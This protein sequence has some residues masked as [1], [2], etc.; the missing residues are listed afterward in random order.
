M[1]GMSSEPTLVMILDWLFFVSSGMFKTD[2]SSLLLLIRK[3]LSRASSKDG[4]DNIHGSNFGSWLFIGPQLTVP[5][6]PP[7]PWAIPG[8]SLGLGPFLSLGPGFRGR[9]NQNSSWKNRYS[10]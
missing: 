10:S 3:P 4:C 9:N 1:L 2:D 7:P 6:G 5:L 8:L